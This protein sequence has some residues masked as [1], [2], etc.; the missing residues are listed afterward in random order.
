MKS[1]NEYLKV[2]EITDQN[3]SEKEIK[4]QY[5]KLC[6]IYHTDN[7][8]TGN[9]E[10]FLEIDE[11]KNAL[12]SNSFKEEEKNNDFIKFAND[13]ISDFLKNYGTNIKIKNKQKLL[14]YKANANNILVLNL[15]HLTKN[16]SFVI[17]NQII[18]FLLEK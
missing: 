13:K 6:K 16:K 14:Y 5:R 2:L 12:L 3:P 10:K 1:K 4:S 15:K 9:H 17:N 7:P 11:A 8:N 18:N